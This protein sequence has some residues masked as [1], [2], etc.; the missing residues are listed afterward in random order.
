MDDE[1]FSLTLVL[2]R[3]PLEV[4]AAVNRVADWWSGDVQGV[5]NR[6]GGTFTYEVAGV[7]H[8]EQ[9]V[10]ELVPGSR[11][12]WH[13]SDADLTF[14]QDRREWKGTD[15][16]FEIT[17]EDGRTRLAFTHRGL[18]PAFECHGACSNAW[19]L[20]VGGN[21]RNLI[22]TGVAQPSPW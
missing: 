2:D 12:V 5:T 21:L 15:I 14:V 1:S 19:N 6:V 4:F 17:E 3:S 11:V 10:T 8:S 7:H 20:L 18:V 16:V 22:Q 13:V 9:T